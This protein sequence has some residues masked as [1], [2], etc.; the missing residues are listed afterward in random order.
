MAGCF[1]QIGPLLQQRPWKKL[2]L[3]TFLVCLMSKK[4]FPCATS[5]DCATFLSLSSVHIT[6]ILHGSSNSQGCVGQMTFFVF[7]L[8]KV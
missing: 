4:F 6:K 5:K 1:F 7:H 2:W 3:D 8:E